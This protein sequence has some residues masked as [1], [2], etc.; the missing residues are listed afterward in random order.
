[1]PVINKVSKTAFV[2]LLAILACFTKASAADDKTIYAFHLVL[3][4]IEF[5]EAYELAEYASKIGY[6]TLI[7]D[8]RD[9]VP[10]L[11]EN[12]Q[13]CSNSWSEE[14]VEDFVSSVKA[15]DMEII[16]EIKLLT[17]QALFFRSHFPDLMYNRHTY[18]PADSRVYPVVFEYLDRV[19]EIFSPNS[20]H[21]GHDEVAGH[22]QDS[23]DRNGVTNGEM[24]PAT[25]Y[26]KDVVILNNYI[27]SKNIDVWMWGDMLISPEEFPD[28]F[29]RHLHGSTPGY[30]KQLRD[31][32]P[33]DI[34]ICDWHYFGQRKEY[35]SI[36]AF[37]DEGFS[38]LAST[39]SQQS[40]TALFAS[41]ANEI[42]VNGFI[43]TTWWYVQKKEWSK[44]H[45]I[46]RQSIMAYQLEI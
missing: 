6:T 33:K 21:I 43:A 8:I 41:Y 36:K 32:I 24:L 14:E 45:S 16:P 28:M 23:T 9:T 5:S 46:L 42:E 22:S 35:P 20:I 15:L 25:L 3:S 11:K 38:V 10:I 30:G 26:L 31:K 27:K 2:I 13:N 34:T 12:C 44:V 39:W 18:N 19:V 40:T 4:G 29:G 7:V 17:H 37:K 1:M